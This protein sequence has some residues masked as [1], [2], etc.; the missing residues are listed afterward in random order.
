[1][2]ILTK[3]SLIWW[4]RITFYV[5]LSFLLYSFLISTLP[6]SLIYLQ[7][8]LIIALIVP[9]IIIEIPRF[10]IY[11]HYF[12]LTLSKKSLVNIFY[13]GLIALFVMLTL[14]VFLI[15]LGLKISVNTEFTINNMLYNMILFFSIALTEEILFRG[16]IFQTL[17]QR[18]RHNF[19]III[20]ALLFSIL[21][22]GNDNAGLIS[23]LNI[24][25][26]GLILGFLILKKLDLW[27]CISFHF[28]WNFLQVLILD[29]P[30]SGINFDFNLIEI[31]YNNINDT[32]RLLAGNEF[33]I[34]SGIMTLFL[35]II[36][37]LN[38]I[39]LVK[40]DYKKQ[41]LNIK[42]IR[43]ENYRLNS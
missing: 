10:K 20:F 11:R 39:Y 4:L 28:F 23:T 41:K 29:S 36:I 1:M 31:N 6:Y 21:H 42:R 13:G 16:L 2:R 30:V 33:G 7:F 35:E 43:M 40:P 8:H 37:L 19:I 26:A 17:I 18:F 22:L 24:F 32:I 27:Y 12:G 14:F 3:I 34:E 15:I 38:I 5:I 25:I 9:I